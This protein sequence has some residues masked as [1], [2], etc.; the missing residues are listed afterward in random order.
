MTRA[1]LRAVADVAPAVGTLAGGESV[2]FTLGWAQAKHVV[3][4]VLLEDDTS[5]D[6]WLA[7]R[8]YTPSA[9]TR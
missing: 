4:N 7:V 5:F 3:P 6:A 8:R 9:T 2:V 1:A